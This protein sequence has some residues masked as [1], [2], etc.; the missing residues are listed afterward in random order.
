M[1]ARLVLWVV[2]RSFVGLKT[3]IFLSL[4]NSIALL[5]RLI[6][7]SHVF[8]FRRSRIPTYVDDRSSGL[9]VSPRRCGSNARS[10]L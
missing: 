7:G 4:F 3:M 5:T 6:G 9:S 10:L 2:G 8:S 1:A